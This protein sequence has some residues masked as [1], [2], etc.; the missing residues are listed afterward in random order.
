MNLGD[1]VRHWRLSVSRLWLLGVTAA[2]S[3]IIGFS[4]VRAAEPGLSEADPFAL[5]GRPADGVGIPERRPDLRV[6]HLRHHWTGEELAVTYKIGERYLPEAMGE[7]DRFMRDW[8]CNQST[9]MDPKLI[10][11]LYELQ[12]A[13]GGRRT[14]RVISAYRSEGYNAS[15]LRAG[16][17]VD[18][19]SQH[20]F[21]RAVDVFVPGM[22]LDELREVAE[23]TGNGGTGYYPFSGPRFIHVDT[24]PARHWSEMDPG[25]KRRLNLPVPERK[26]LQL[27]CSLTMAQVLREVPVAEVMAALPSG[28]ATQNGSHLHPAAYARPWAEGNGGETAAVSSIPAGLARSDGPCQEA[29]GMVA[30]NPA[31]LLSQ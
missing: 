5:D 7:I 13:L 29:G 10:D 31:A 22:R 28:A 1:S 19:D 17:T 11:R 9:T 4:T 18:P 24:G 12:V 21:G 3:A 8:R 26:P 6:L 2:I 23:K 14:M 25:L 15:L 20:M 27:D 30:L 16:R